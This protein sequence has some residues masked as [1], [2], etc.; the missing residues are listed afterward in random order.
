MKIKRLYL[1]AFILITALAF[2][3]RF[4]RLGEIPNGLYQDETAIGYN[5]YSIIQTGRDEYGKSLPLYFKSFGD[6][7]LPVYIYATV[8]SILM[9][10]LTE[11]AVRAP[12]ALFGSLSVPL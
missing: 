8:P 4:W 3:L 7:K 9:L 2:L 1:I 10:G 12:S 6:Y 5:A 11:L